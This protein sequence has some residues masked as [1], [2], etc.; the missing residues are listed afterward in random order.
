MR[1]V[2]VMY[3][4]MLYG[5]LLCVLCAWLFRSMCLCVSF[6]THCVYCVCSCVRCRMLCLVLFR[7]RV[8]CVAVCCVYCVI[9]CVML[10][11]SCF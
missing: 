6:M 4:V 10:Y 5:L 1:V 8:C 11:D 3:C 2:F 9:Y 7:V